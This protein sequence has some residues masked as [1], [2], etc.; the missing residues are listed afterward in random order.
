MDRHNLKWTHQQ[1][2]QMNNKDYQLASIHRYKLKPPF[3]NGDY[4]TFEEWKYIFTAC[5]GLLDNDYTELV[6]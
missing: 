3:Y 5:I 1:H 4:G 2:K 6:Q